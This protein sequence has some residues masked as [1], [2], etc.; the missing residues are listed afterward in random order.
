MM[1]STRFMARRSEPDTIISDNGTKFFGAA[2][3]ITKCFKEWDRKA[4]CE[5]LARG[6]IIWK[7]NPT[8]DPHFG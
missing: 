7:F 2:Q 8:A 1:V 4:V 6:Q 5:R 3:E